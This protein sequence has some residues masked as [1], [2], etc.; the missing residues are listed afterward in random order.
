MPYT[1]FD[2]ETESWLEPLNLERHIPRITVAATLSSEQG[3]RLWVEADQNGDV[4]GRFLGLGR[5]KELVHYLREQSEHGHTVVTWNGTGFDFR[6]LAKASGERVACVELAWSHVDLMFWLHCRKG[7]SVSLASA[8]KAIGS[9]KSEGLSGADIPKLWAQREYDRVLE[10]VAQD[11]RV[12]GEVYTWALDRSVL[13]WTNARGGQSSLRGRPLVV[14]EAH[15]LPLPDTSWMR[16]PPWPRER[17]VGW[18]G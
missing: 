4:T 17:F 6:V 7:F 13:S 16:G 18:M 1:I 15:R 14:R 8:A 3:L 10:Y 5:A 9:G 11:A 12:T 2:L